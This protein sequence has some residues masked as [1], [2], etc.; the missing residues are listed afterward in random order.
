MAFQELKQELASLGEP[1]KILLLRFSSLGD[2]LMTTAMIRAVRTRFPHAR[3][4][5]AVREDFKGLV[6]TNPHLDRIWTIKRGAGM[7]GLFRLAHDLNREHY[8][9]VYDAHRSL[10]S[11]F[12][13][14]RVSAKNKV[15]YAKHYLSRSLALTI[16]FPRL[17]D[18]TRML[19]RFIEPLEPYGVK[20]D[21]RGPEFIVTAVQAESARNK[22]P[23]AT[24]T[25]RFVGIV[26]TAQ[27]E[28]KRWAADRFHELVRRLESQN[29]RVLIFGGKGDT[30]CGDIAAGLSPERVLNLQ[31]KTSLAESAYWLSRCSVVVANDTG[32]MHLADAQ[33]VPTVVIFGPTSG[34]L[35]CLPFHPSSQTLEPQLWCRPCSKNGEAPCIRGRRLCLEATQV[36]DVWNKTI[37]F[38]GAE[39]RA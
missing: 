3:I 13:M 9:L 28:G 22:I 8:D 17:T 24:E 29:Q 27:W 2:I 7:K 39:N 25:E 20:Y 33:G 14:A 15:T 4:D 5:F 37:P 6:E 30:F 23:D 16:K 26:P 35:G 11:R 21:G 34:E 32:L 36:D 10:R 19:E 31:G 12:L 38:L 18:R 1:K